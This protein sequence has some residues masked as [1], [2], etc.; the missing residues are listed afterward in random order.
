M[1]SYIFDPAYIY[2]FCY[3]FLP[4]FHKTVWGLGENSFLSA[5]SQILKQ[6]S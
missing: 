6:K 5:R 4:T 2:T 3:S 1:K